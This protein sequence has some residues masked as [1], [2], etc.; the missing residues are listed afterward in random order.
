MLFRSYQALLNLLTNGDNE[1]QKSSL[2]AL[3]AWKTLGVIKYQEHL[4]N[5]LDDARFREE[6]SVFLRLEEEG[7]AIRS[8][9][10]PELMPVLLRILY[11][12]AVTRAGSASG[13]RGQQTRR[14]AIFVALARFPANII[15]QFLEISLGSL[16]KHD[17]IK[18]GSLDK[19]AVE[20]FTFA[21]RKQVG[22]LNMLDDMVHTLGNRLDTFA[23]KIADAVLLLALFLFDEY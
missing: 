9:D 12:K 18:N 2:K 6:V 21:P 19:S 17:P 5:F 8:A 7:D 23:T 16:A 11:G 22:M 4:L 20:S 13:K 1:I 10:C 3:L 15:G 14:K